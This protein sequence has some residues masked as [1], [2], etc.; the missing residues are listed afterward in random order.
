[1]DRH[2]TARQTTHIN[3]IKRMRLA[4]PISKATDTRAECLVPIAIP[5]QLWLSERVS[6]FRY[7]CFASFVRIMILVLYVSRTVFITQGNYMGYMSR[8]LNSHLQAYSLQ[9][10]SQDAVHTLGSHCVYSSEVLKPDHLPRKVKR[11]KCVTQ[12]LK[13]IKFFLKK[14]I[15]VYLTY[16]MVQRP[17]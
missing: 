1:M 17:S 14:C 6:T 3:K 4:Y 11:A 12:W 8:L 15:G 5:P 9:V 7:T 10:E 13:Y 2:S 16:S